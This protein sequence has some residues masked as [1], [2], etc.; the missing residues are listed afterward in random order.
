MDDYNP[1][2]LSSSQNIY[3]SELLS[4][5]TPNIM[6]G[7]NDIFKE[8]CKL[9]TENEEDE[10]Y[11]M[12]FQNFI[13]KIPLWSPDIIETEVAR[14][15]EVSHCSYL[16][17]LLTGVHI[18]QLKALTCVRV[19]SHQKKIDIIIPKMTDFIHKVYINTYRKLYTNVYLFERDITPLLYH[20]NQREFELLVQFATL[21]AIRETIPIEQILRTYMDTSM[22]EDIELLDEEPVKEESSKEEPVKEEDPTKEEPIKFETITFD[23]T[24]HSVDISG[25]E[26]HIIV[27]KDISSLEKSALKSAEREP[28][29]IDDEDEKMIIGE[30][31]NNNLQVEV[32]SPSSIIGDIEILS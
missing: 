17:N 15:R 16:D 10:K 13:S 28:N 12:T 21:D 9:C 26:E 25:N 1:I 4:I 3:V 24:D 30:T 23:D 29:T 5:I 14:I 19:G 27:P 7:F 22:E 31:L 20:K 6:D 2:N 18:I 32:M 8:S 11:L